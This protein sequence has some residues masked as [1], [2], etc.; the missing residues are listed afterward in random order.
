MNT[1]TKEVK[2]SMNRFLNKEN[3]KDKFLIDILIPYLVKHMEDSKY[4]DAVEQI[5]SMYVFP[6]KTE[7]GT[8][9]GSLA[10]PGIRWYFEKEDKKE[11][12][13]AVYSSGSYRIFDLSLLSNAQAAE[14]RKTVKECCDIEDF[15][16]N[17]VIKDIL[18]KMGE[19]TEYTKEWWMYA[20]DVFKLWNVQDFN[21]SL[22]KATQS[23]NNNSF[24][25]LEDSYAW[26]I[27]E[28]L[29]NF[30]VFIDVVDDIS[31]HLFW[32]RL[33]DT[34][35][36]KKAVDMLKRM[37]VP[38]EFVDESGVNQCILDFFK[39]I[40]REVCFPLPFGSNEHE[41]CSLCQDI[42]HQMYEYHYYDFCDLINDSEY[43]GGMVIANVRE[44]YVPLSWN[45]FYS[46]K[47]VV[48]SEDGN[49][50]EDE[51]YE[52]TD[53]RLEMQHINIDLYDDNYITAFQ[54][55]YRFSD[56]CKHADEYVLGIDVQPIEFYKWV[57]YYSKHIDLAQN[58]LYFF[59]DEEEIY[60]D[61]DIKFAL[62]VL[63]TEEVYDEGYE[64]K[65]E[66]DAE[67]AFENGRVLNK[68]SRHFDNICCFVNEHSEL[69]DKSV[70]F[71]QI[72]A[73]INDV[74]SSQ[75]ILVDS[76]WD[77]VF[78][79]E[80]D[81]TLYYGKYVVCRDDSYE[82]RILLCKSNST[83][84][85]VSALSRYVQDFFGVEVSIGDL[86]DIN[87]KKAYINLI[88]GIRSFVNYHTDKVP[89]DE[90]YKYIVDLNDI[91][92]FGEEKSLW[93]RLKEQRRL[94]IETEKGDTPFELLDNRNF[95]K[96]KYNGR[97]QICG[98][99]APKN[100]QDSYF[101]TYRIVK[102]SKNPLANM[103]YNLFCL[104]PTCH[105]ELG[106]GRFMGQDMSDVVEK[107]SMYASYIEDKLKSDEMED[108]FP[109]LVQE[110]VDHE[111]EI[112][113]FHKPIICNVMINGKE[114][115]M[116]FSWEH[117]IKVAFVFADINDFDEED[118]FVYEKVNSEEEYEP[119]VI[120]HEIPLRISH[121]H[122]YGSW[123]GTE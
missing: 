61:S 77:R 15:S 23:M 122:G 108:D 72:I 56:V 93:L 28:K 10:E 16:D 18:D 44:E 51:L 100:A 76:I 115:K 80:E 55:I 49:G 94:L 65:F 54:Q 30:S 68:I 9:I 90:V 81:S 64:F 42:M 12:K 46:D 78:V 45:L 25:F 31:K 36:L 84:S 70:F 26:K 59:S 121:P 47:E 109:C 86:S 40:E 17:A 101:Y 123:H 113:G 116:A 74:A 29:V 119:E 85:Y 95:L 50:E 11:K 110:L 20:Y 82:N 118:D 63:G 112:E 88:N 92:T 87:W 7:R 1:D 71:Q 48:D 83:E 43:N 62:E 53:S 111:V 117:F 66:V 73:A 33:A 120:N 14:F 24:M 22:S 98:N 96:S 75:Q 21:S 38:F 105:G 19:E 89:E 102:K 2:V 97:C 52:I 6:Y 99:M 5:T 58:I 106:Y 13:K 60:N 41:M 34:S 32:S 91:E 39:R 35:D 79:I 107:A 4:D 69:L 37:G 57:W 67:T 27:K 104:C 114:Q 8:R 103:R 3:K